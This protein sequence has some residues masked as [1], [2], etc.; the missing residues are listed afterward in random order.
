[1]GGPTEGTVV[2]PKA[3]PVEQNAR[4]SFD[5]ATA[6]KARTKY[7]QCVGSWLDP[8]IPNEASLHSGGRQDQE[9]TTAPALVGE[10]QDLSRIPYLRIPELVWVLLQRG[11]WVDLVS[12]ARWPVEGGF[13]FTT[14]G[15]PDD[16]VQKVQGQHLKPL[17]RQALSQQLTGD[18]IFSL[19][20][21][22]PQL[23]QGVQDDEARAGLHMTLVSYVS[24]LRSH[25]QVIMPEIIEQHGFK[26]RHA[27]SSMI[28]QVLAS[29]DLRSRGMLRKVAKK[30]HSGMLAGST[31]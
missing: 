6:S 30:V 15:L 3:P 14:S 24:A 22:A 12:L 17:A 13:L 16:W 11:H 19:K 25:R 31:C 23:L 2:G 28:H 18:L 10:D 8:H 1:M 27:S 9:Y 5:V 4:G 20:S 7:L 26:F 21:W 29:L